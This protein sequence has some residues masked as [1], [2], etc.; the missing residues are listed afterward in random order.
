MTGLKG[1]SSLYMF[2][3]CEQ[4]ALWFGKANASP[5]ERAHVST[6]LLTKT[7][8]KENIKQY[9]NHIC[10]MSDLKYTVSKSYLQGMLLACFSELMIILDEY[11]PY[12]QLTSSSRIVKVQRMV[13]YN[14]KDPRLNVDFVSRLVSCSP[15]H[16][17]Q[18]F[19]K[20]TGT[21]LSRYINEERLENAKQ[22]LKTTDMNIKQI[23]YSCGYS[24]S[25][26][27]IRIFRKLTGTTP[28]KYRKSLVK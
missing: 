23:A 14:L 3:D 1:E 11:V 17:S 20:K 8:R 18:M 4:S 12:E 25:S 7:D 26:Y 15:G 9:L 24:E 6:L 21:K 27:F 19:Y 5:G 28:N 13:L 22:L 10:D 16:L 2:V